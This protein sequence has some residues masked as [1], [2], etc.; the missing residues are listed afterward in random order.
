MVLENMLLREKAFL[1]GTILRSFGAGLD[2]LCELRPGGGER[3]LQSYTMRRNAIIDRG[4][5]N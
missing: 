1:E 5:V 3:R 2:E 4:Q